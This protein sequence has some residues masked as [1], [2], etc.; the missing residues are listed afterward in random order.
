MTSKPN[1]VADT[2]RWQRQLLPLMTRMVVG[3]TLF[4]F[5]ASFAQLLYLQTEI[6]RDE[7]IALSDSALGAGVPVGA[8]MAERLAAARFRAAAEL[9]LQV[10]TRRYRQA[11]VL[12]MSRVWTL[13]LGFV[14]GMILALVGAAF[15]LGKL[16]EPM[17]EL[18][19]QS[20]GGDLTLK[21][22]SPGLI[23]AALGTALMLATIVTHHRIDVSDGPSYFR[24]G[25]SASDTPAKE[26][27]PKLD[28]PFT[29][30]AP[31]Q[32]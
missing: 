17:S 30:S 5:V 19:L 7:P 28:S 31:K 15:I 16:Q 22:A 1:G 9:E 29:P 10:V 4:F 20:A 3:L 24:D 13:Y 21:T 14:T 26:P 25:W 27:P 32:P 18:G 12:L 11:T 6:R 8:S 2:K 23:L